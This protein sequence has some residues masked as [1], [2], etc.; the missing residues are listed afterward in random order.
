MLPVNLGFIVLALAFVAVLGFDFAAIG[1]GAAPSWYGR[2]RLPVTL[3]V[4][5]SLLAASLAP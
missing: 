1:N 5:L 2:L 4:V 3:V